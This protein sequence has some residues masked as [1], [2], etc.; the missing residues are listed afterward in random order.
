MGWEVDIPAQKVGDF[1]T[2]LA[3]EFWLG[4]TRNAQCTLH[5]RQLAG[6]NSHHI[7]EGA[8]KSAARAIAQAVRINPEYADEIPSTKGVI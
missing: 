8:F 7:I 6:T 5:F 3:Q 1:D 4:F 2:E